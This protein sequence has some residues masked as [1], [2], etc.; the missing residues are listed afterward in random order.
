MPQIYKN[1]EGKHYKLPENHPMVSL[2]HLL[3]II[4]VS[5]VVIICFGLLAGLAAYGPSMFKEFS[6]ILSGE[7]LSNINFL[8]FFQILSTI[9]VFIIPSYILLRIERNRTFYFNHSLP[10]PKSLFLL[11]FLVLLASMPLLELSALINLEMQLPTYLSGLEEWMK[12]KELEAEKITHLLINTTTYSGLL[13]NLIMIAVFPAIGEEL[14]FRGIIQ[15]I[16]TRWIKSPHFAIWITAILFSAIH[17]QFYGFLPRMLIGAL[18]GYLYYWG[19][20]I[21]LPILAHFIN[22]A[23]VTITVFFQLR[24]GLSMEEIDNTQASSWYIYII[25][26]IGTAIII[27]YFWKISNREKITLEE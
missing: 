19:K 24:Q 7:D 16:F 15:N 1:S 9:G 18:F 21:W 14:L 12:V 17:M 22:N 20:S 25:S 5:S 26:F 3:L 27:Y 2:I 23:F 11:A 4:L 10:N 13:I 6:S 8:K